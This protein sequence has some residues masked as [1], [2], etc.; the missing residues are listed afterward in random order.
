MR[1]TRKNLRKNNK[2]RRVK[3]GGA[4]RHDADDDLRKAYRYIYDYKGDKDGPYTSHWLN[5][6]LKVTG[7]NGDDYEKIEKINDMLLE[8]YRM[9]TIAYDNFEKLMEEDD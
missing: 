5:E 9:M 6:Y 2:S 7:R 1:K 8:G 3:R 4:P